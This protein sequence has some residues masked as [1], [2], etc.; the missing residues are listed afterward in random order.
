MRILE[1]ISWVAGFLF[2]SFKTTAI[3]EYAKLFPIFEKITHF[4]E[5]ETEKQHDIGLSYKMYYITTHDS[6]F[7]R[8]ITCPYCLGAWVSIGFCAIFSCLNWLPIVYFG[9][10]TTYFGVSVIMNRLENMENSDDRRY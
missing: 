5:Y 9:G 1:A 4:K 3:Y 2:V 8:L 7:T 6:F 10:L